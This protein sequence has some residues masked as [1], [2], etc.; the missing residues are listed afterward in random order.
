MNK[1][2][3]VFFFLFQLSFSQKSENLKAVISE[4]NIENLMNLKNNFINSD[5]NK[6]LRIENYL[7]KN[8]NVLRKKVINGKTI[9]LVDVINDEP[10]FAETFNF[11]GATT[12]R[13]NRLYSGGILNLNVQGQGM[14]P[15]VWDNGAVNTNHVEMTG[16]I[17]IGDT[18]SGFGDHASHVGGTIIASGINNSARGIAFNANL[19][20]YDW[21]SDL[22]EM[23]SEAA[24]G[25]LVSNHSYIIS[26]AL[27]AWHFGAY[28]ERARNIDQILFNAPFYTSV[29][30]AGNDRNN[31][32]SLFQNQI[33]T[34]G[35]GYELIRNQGNAKNHIVVGAVNGVPFYTNE[36]DV[37]MSAFS[38][39]GPTDDG[40][41]KPDIVAKGVNVFSTGDASDNHYYTSQGTSM[42]SP[43]ITGGITLLQQH[44][45]NVNSAY[46]RSATVKALITNTALEAGDHLG[47]DYRFGWGLADIANAAQLI[48][49]R[50]SGTSIINELTLNNGASYT[51]NLNA[52]GTQPLKVT[53]CWTDPAALFANSGFVDPTTRYLV[54]DLDLR[55]SRNNNT[56]FPWK[57]DKND[58]T[59]PATRN[60]D[61][62]IDVIETVQIDNPVQGNY[63]ITVSHKGTLVN[64]SQNFSLIVSGVN[65]TLSTPILDNSHIFINP[66]PTTDKL[67]VNTSDV[68]VSKYEIFDLQGR[69][70]KRSQINDL[71][72]FTIDMND[73]NVGMY[74][75][76]IQS[77]NGVSSHKIIKK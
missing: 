49:N 74:L 60:S 52:T 62:N 30:A 1:L 75:I 17:S 76:Q 21:N 42:A 58:P 18:P 8:S 43:M 24:T 9:E 3:L 20:S 46:M 14:T 10:I 65:Q 15:A 67:F 38:S 48:S 23:T 32:G 50:A 45:H 31:T 39:W 70:V 55:V 12:I 59:A 4:T 29:W 47:P 5:L 7:A 19:K 6:D 36:S 37:V 53:I 63:Q 41:I 56:F 71:T 11:S 68:P 64:N 77:A 27:S 26:P 34:K 16:R 28:D 69:L 44:Y 57:L 33:N 25:L 40:R 72:S 22:S 66:N 51:L 13:A 61:N 73:I 54:N 2:Y 35:G